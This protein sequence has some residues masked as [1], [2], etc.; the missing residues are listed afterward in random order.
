V[1]IQFINKIIDF[2]ENINKAKVLALMGLPV[3]RRGDGDHAIGHRIWTMLR[4]EYTADDIRIDYLLNNW[5]LIL[6]LL[7][8]NP[9]TLRMISDASDEAAVESSSS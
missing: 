7:P 6:P 8:V 3:F 1:T 4:N 2:L 5:E 9:S